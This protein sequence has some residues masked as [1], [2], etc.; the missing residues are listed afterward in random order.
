MFSR[1][2]AEEP[3]DDLPGIEMGEIDAMSRM[4]DGETLDSDRILKV[5]PSLEHSLKLR[6]DTLLVLVLF[7][8]CDPSIQLDRESNHYNKEFS[9]M[10]VDQEDPPSR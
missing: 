5:C 7:S 3:N 8:L 2:Y 1:T 10:S 6:M 9:V 4:R